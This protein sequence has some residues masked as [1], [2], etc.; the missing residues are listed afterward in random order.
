MYKT[1]EEMRARLAEIVAKLGEY[2]GM[3]NMGQEEIDSVNTLSEEYDTLKGNIEAK[4]KIAAMTADANK[5]ERKVASTPVAKVEVR[6]QKNHGFKSGGEFFMAVKKAA[7]GDLD[8]RFK[9]THFEKYGEDGGFLVPEDFMSAI[10]KKVDGDESL[11]AKTRQLRVSGNS[12][13]INIDQSTPWNGGLQAYWM[14]EGGQYTESKIQLGQAS[15]RLHKLGVLV[16]CT[17]ELLEDASALESYVKM[18]APE[19]INHKLNGAIISGDGVAKPT[20]ILNSGFRVTVAKESGQTADTVVAANIVKMYA[21]MIPSARSSAAWYINPEVEPALRLLQDGAGNYIYMAPGSQMNQTPY[22]ML[23]GRPVIPLLGGMKA[24]GDEGDI[25][26]ADLSYY[27]SILKTSGLKQAM[28][29]H[30]YFDRDITAFKFMIRVDGH[31]PFSAPIS[32]EFGAQKLSGIVT[33]A[34]R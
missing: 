6:E 15:W 24:I 30:L 23:L 28:S 27:Y 14:E 29:T 32:P 19:A 31:C 3:E 12:L 20:G 16:K 11:L 7:T 10:N 5:F 33:L 9:N 17:D 8:K 34:A 25:I 2:E 13:T 4:E 1:I 26:F 18:M 21:S 22:G